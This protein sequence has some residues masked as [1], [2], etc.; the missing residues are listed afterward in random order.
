MA[1]RGEVGDGARESGKRHID[2]H[3]RE[4]VEH[5]FV[6]GDEGCAVEEGC[7]CAESD[8]CCGVVDAGVVLDAAAE[9]DECEGLV[10]R[11]CGG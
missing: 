4:A 10:H 8:G 9:G 2:G 11:G 3:R 5:G 6:C 1:E 7:Y